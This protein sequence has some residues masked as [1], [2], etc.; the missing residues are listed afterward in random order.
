MDLHDRIYV[1]AASGLSGDAHRKPGRAQVTIV[2]A[3]K[4][5]DACVALGA[6]ACA[7]V[8]CR[9]VQSG[10]VE[11]EDAVTWLTDEERDEGGASPAATEPQL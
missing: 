9:I 2:S 7:G 4:W 1:D 11:V 10:P 3:E 6:D 5:A 8:R